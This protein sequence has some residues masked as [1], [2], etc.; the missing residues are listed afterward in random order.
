MHIVYA[1]ENESKQAGRHGTGAIAESLHS[2]NKHEV[3][4][5]LTENGTG[6]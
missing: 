5:M 6:F 4:S 2:I 3:Q 1:R